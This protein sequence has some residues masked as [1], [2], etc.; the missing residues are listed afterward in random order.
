M[1]SSPVLFPRGNK[2][3][4]ALIIRKNP[5]SPGSGVGKEGCLELTRGGMNRTH[6]AGFRIVYWIFVNLL[7][8]GWISIRDR[9]GENSWE[10]GECTK[11]RSPPFVNEW[12]SKW[13]MS[14]WVTVAKPLINL[15]IIR[16]KVS[17]TLRPIIFDFWNVL[18]AG[19]VHLELP[20]CSLKLARNDQ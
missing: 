20:Y 5:L 3:R 8:G 6:E 10:M 14:V 13:L 1:T 18:C 11:N 16:G 15:L 17:K 19:R 2:C 12:I 9:P 7:A 4:G